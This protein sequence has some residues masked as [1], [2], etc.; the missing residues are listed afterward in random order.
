[1]LIWKKGRLISADEVTIQKGLGS[2]Y[3]IYQISFSDRLINL[4]S[5]YIRKESISTMS[6]MKNMETQFSVNIQNY[7]RWGLLVLPVFK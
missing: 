7:A 1:M 3:F 4:E 6:I 2:E 5:V